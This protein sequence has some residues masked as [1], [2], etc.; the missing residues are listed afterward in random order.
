MENNVELSNQT[1]KRT[2]EVESP[3]NH[4]I[5]YAISILLTALAFFAVA[6]PALNKT[7]KIVFIVGMATI[8]V[9]FQFVFWMH[10]K[11]KG[12]IYAAI[13]IIF[14]VVIALCA[15]VAAVFWM[16]W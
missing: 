11:E 7:F 6:N 12:H 4:Y 3:R 13:G 14:G 15:A 1:V 8:Q 2:S 16:W 10:M 5:S 9:I